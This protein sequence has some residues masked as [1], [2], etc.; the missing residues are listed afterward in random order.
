MNS[1]AESS[2]NGARVSDPSPRDFVDCLPTGTL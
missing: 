1:A 2:A